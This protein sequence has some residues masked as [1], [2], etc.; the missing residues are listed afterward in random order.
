MGDAQFFFKP[1]NFLFEEDLFLPATI[2]QPVRLCQW[3]SSQR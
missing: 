3:F 1:P 2:D